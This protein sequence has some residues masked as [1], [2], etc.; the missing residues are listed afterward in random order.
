ML[1][2]TQNKVD[3]AVDHFKEEVA[4]I[5]TGRAN[6]NIIDDVKVEYYGQETQLKEV[7]NV[8]IPEPRQ[9][10]VEVWDENAVEAVEKGLSEADLGASPNRI[11]DK[12]L[13]IN[14]PSLT[15]EARKRM[16]K[17]LHDK[18]EQARVSVRN[19]REDKWKET[20]A[21]ERKGEITEDDKYTIKDKL[22]DMV[23]EANEEIERVMEKKEE[24]IEV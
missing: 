5:R 14:L 8:S 16:V 6:S 11:D 22:Q 4:K 24:E 13:I 10:R 19:I 23:D 15:G 17:K 2:K 21:E 3:Q 12:T 20:Q 18:A 1:E 9:I 7:A